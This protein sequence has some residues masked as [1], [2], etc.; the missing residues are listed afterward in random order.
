MSLRGYLLWLVLVAT[1]PALIFSAWLIYKSADEQRTSI[2]AEIEDSAEILAR[3]ID[4]ELNQ[5]I[6]ALDVLAVSNAL[7]SDDLRGFHAVARR[8]LKNHPEWANIVLV[9]PHGEHLVNLNLPYGSALPPLSKP[10]VFLESAR[11]KSPRVS[12]A[13][14]GVT[15]KRLLTV[16]AVPVM[17]DGEVKYVLGVAQEA[18]DWEQMMR[19]RLPRGMQATL[20]D[21]EYTIVARTLDNERFAGK[22][23][24]KPLVDGVAQD[25]GRGEL[26]G[27]TLDGFPGHGFYRRLAF[28]GWTVAVFMPVESFEQPMRAVLGQLGA[29]FLLLI[30]GTLAIAWWL[31]RWIA[32][33]ITQLAESVQAVGRGGYPLPV[34]TRIREVRAANGALHSAAALLAGRLHREQAVREDLELADRAKDEYLAML[35]HELR[36]PLAPI[37]AALYILAEEPLSGEAARRARTVI[38]RQAQHLSRLVD[39]LLDVTRLASGKVELH[40]EAL[41]VDDVLRQAVEDHAELAARAKVHLALEAPP[42]PV[43]VHGDRTRLAQIAGNLLQNAVRFTPAGGHV[44]VSLERRGAEAR[45]SVRDTGTGIEPQLL[46][47]LF[48][49]F[50]QGA[51]VAARAKGGLGL[52]LV[53]VKGLAELHGGR[54]EAFSA[55]P[56]KG[57]EF[58]VTLPAL[59]DH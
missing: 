22:K 12:N 4:A 42:E 53:L 25:P 16:V 23:P 2:K 21:R 58:I 56:G 52:G 13:T 20:M 30:A 40:R 9:G 24:A 51:H 35:A 19:D 34:D 45:I 38:G 14:V 57:A 29:G 18:N 37:N 55:G 59:Q 46:P 15:V 6:G 39:D 7:A 47:R 50:V 44:T 27:I 33:A 32:S 11:D 28:S 17:R 10:E 49:P 5:I 3:D 41:S 43:L 26:R 31:G 8:V 36:N 48:E 54:V 1:L